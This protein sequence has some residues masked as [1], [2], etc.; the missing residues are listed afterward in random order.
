MYVAITNLD[1]LQV[2]IAYPTIYLAALTTIFDRRLELS[3]NKPAGSSLKACSAE[4]TSMES[5][6][7]LHLHWCLRFKSAGWW[8]EQKRQICLLGLTVDI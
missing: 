3:T 4:P 5:Y 8:A 2:G 7:L 6:R 1:N